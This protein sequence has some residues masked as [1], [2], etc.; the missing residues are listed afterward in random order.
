MNTTIVWVLMTLV[1]GGTS[2]P[3]LEFTGE[4]KCLAAA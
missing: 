3:T 4:K 1:S 2:V